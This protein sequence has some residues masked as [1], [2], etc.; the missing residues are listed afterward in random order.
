[1]K[2]RFVITDYFIGLDLGR[3]RDYSAVV[4]L[5]LRQEEHGSY[6][7]QRLVQPTRRILEVIGLKRIARGTEYVKVVG[8]VRRLISRLHARA[9]WGAAPV[10]V[11]L[12]MDSAGPGQVALELVRAQRMD[13]NFIPAILTAGHEHGRS[14]SGK[15][16]VPRREIIAT[17]R[18]LLE[19]ELFRLHREH[20]HAE[21]LRKEVAAV[22]PDGGQY[23]HDDLVIAAALAVWY[24][25][26][27][28]P[29]II[30]PS[31]IAA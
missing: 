24:A 26:R 8:Y 23:A 25:T 16:T 22:R 4:I 30:R 21:I 27:A 1:M 12:I 2:R 18:Y 5:A 7:H 31:A 13:I 20:P 9:G 28:Y 29:D 6:D 19:V 3:D 17:L 10:R 15:T 11:H 14:P